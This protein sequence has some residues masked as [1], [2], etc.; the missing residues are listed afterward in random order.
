MMCVWSESGV[1]FGGLHFFTVAWARPGEICRRGG[2]P[3]DGH[4]REA[5]ARRV[6]FGEC[7]ALRLAGL[8]VAYA[9]VSLASLLR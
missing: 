2:L 9:A 8:R 6:V 1:A 4:G 3:A 7:A 5:L